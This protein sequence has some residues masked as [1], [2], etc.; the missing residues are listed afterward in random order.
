MPRR[1]RKFVSKRPAGEISSNDSSIDNRLL[2]EL[3]SNGV[4]LETLI[5]TGASR[6]LLSNRAF[7]EIFHQ[8]CIR[9][10]PGVPLQNLSG[11]QI[12]H[13]GEV[14]IY[15]IK[16]KIPVTIVETLKYDFLL[17]IDGLKILNGQ[18]NCLHNYIT[19]NNKKYESINLSEKDYKEIYGIEGETPTS[20]V[21]KLI[22]KHERLFG[23][24]DETLS[25]TSVGKCILKQG[26]R[27][28]LNNELIE[29]LY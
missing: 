23:E 24:H 11:G 12:K 17:G 26:M 18:I 20:V 1:K 6:S 13:Y 9:F 22:E 16:K 3:Q 21:D 4:N 5:D 8:K 19:L 15:I 29:Y 10:R 14:D 25:T 27:L 7:K 28:L 2:I